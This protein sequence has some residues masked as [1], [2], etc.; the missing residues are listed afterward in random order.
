MK[1]KKTFGRVAIVRNR[2]EKRENVL[3]LFYVYK[4]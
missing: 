3:H 4:Q 1:R 2:E